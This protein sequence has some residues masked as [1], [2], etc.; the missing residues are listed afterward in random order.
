MV[1][2]LYNTATAIFDWTGV[3]WGSSRGTTDP[4]LG[5]SPVMK[6]ELAIALDKPR[7]QPALD[8]PT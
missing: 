7:R 8:A 1:Q 6:R 4:S 3:K 2:N 5:D